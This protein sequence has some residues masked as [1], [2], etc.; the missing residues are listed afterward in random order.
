[1]INGAY[2][3][4]V[5]AYLEIEQRATVLR[6]WQPQVIPGLQQTETYA[7]ADHAWSPG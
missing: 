2:E 3:A 1:M 5:R 4:W 7:R 6:S